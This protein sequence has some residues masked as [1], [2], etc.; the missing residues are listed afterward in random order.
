MSK[1]A[2]QDTQEQAEFR[3]ECRAWLKKNTPEK[4]PVRLPL[5]PVEIMSQEQM[6]YLQACR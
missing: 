1:D 6:D 5:T 4:P 3:S 2:S